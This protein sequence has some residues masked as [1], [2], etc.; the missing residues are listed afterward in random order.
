M[1]YNNHLETP[2]SADK[3][4]VGG[5]PDNPSIARDHVCCHINIRLGCGRNTGR[6]ISI[7][8]RRWECPFEAASYLR[9][10][11]EKEKHSILTTETFGGVTNTWHVLRAL[12]CPEKSAS[13]LV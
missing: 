5:C 4:V 3:P 13:R 12:T 10:A 2:I 6:D 9:L 1:V 8:F 11:N 7:I